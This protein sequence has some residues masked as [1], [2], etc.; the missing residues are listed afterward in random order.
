MN[1]LG[2]TAKIFNALGNQTRLDIIKLILAKK[3]ISC[4]ELRKKFPLSQP[5]MSHHFGLLLSSGI[6]T[7]RKEGV[8][9]FYRVN[10]EKLKSAGINLGKTRKD[11]D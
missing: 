9:Y 10:D 8:R 7:A 11:Q 1:I 4:Q 2:Q 5:T 3:E 6:L